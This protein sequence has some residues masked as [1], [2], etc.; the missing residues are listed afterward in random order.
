MSCN[1]RQPSSD[2]PFFNAEE[3]IARRRAE[4]AVRLPAPDAPSPAHAAT[5][6]RLCREGRIKLGREAQTL[7]DDELP[8]QAYFQR[9]LAAG[10]LPE[11][12]RV[13]AQSLPKRR[14]LWWACLCAQDAYGNAMPTQVAEA[15]EAVLRFLQSPTEAHRRETE[16]I[17]RSSPSSRLEACL[18][19]AAFFSE[20]NISLPHLPPVYPRPYVT[21]RLVGVCVYLASVIR[22]PAQYKAHLRQY[23][24]I[25]TQLAR[26]E[27]LW[28]ALAT[29]P[30]RVDS[31][32]PVPAEIHCQQQ[33]QS[34][35]DPV[36]EP[37]VRERRAS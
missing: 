25:G 32:E 15:I 18:A 37:A 24:E 23:L 7:L 1:C 30:M 29:E 12:R 36:A 5:A 31:S 33:I 22:S 28:L 9:L 27:N 21:G 17:G 11:A 6:R 35:A 8:P 19:M 14:A 34:Q 4:M 10:H 26:G 2:K 20:G 3:A 16:R 13:L